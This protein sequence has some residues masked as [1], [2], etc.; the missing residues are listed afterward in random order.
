MISDLVC[1]SVVSSLVLAERPQADYDRTAPDEGKCGYLIVMVD[2]VL[3][4]L[5]N[6]FCQG[7]GCGS[8][9]RR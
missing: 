8:G 9:H 3:C 2:D 1:F 7:G 5:R 6:E 4:W